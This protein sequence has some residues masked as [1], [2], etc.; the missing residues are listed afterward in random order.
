MILKPLCMV[1]HQDSL[2]TSGGKNYCNHGNLH[3]HHYC[4]HRALVR[5][6]DVRPERGNCGEF[7][8][9]H[10]GKIERTYW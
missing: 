3:H 6:V 9:G 5:S 8:Q 1:I 10:S 4:V 2:T 7:C